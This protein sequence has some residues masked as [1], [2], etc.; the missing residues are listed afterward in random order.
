MQRVTSSSNAHAK[1]VAIASYAAESWQEQLAI[2]AS[3]WTQ[4]QAL[5]STVWLSV[6]GNNA[7]SGWF[8]P[9]A[10][11]TAAPTFGPAF[12]ALGDFVAQTSANTVFCTHVRLTRLL[13][14][15]NGLIRT[16]VRVF[17]PK[18][19]PAWNSGAQYCLTTVT[20]ASITA[21]TSNF[22]FIYDTTVNRQG[23]FD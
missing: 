14:D 13:A 20:T 3:R 19:G 4:S 10:A 6:L 21:A 9:A 7:T 16:E 22:H 5:S 2:D 17:W 1:N 15:P 23:G 12:D 8:T 18:P 11:P